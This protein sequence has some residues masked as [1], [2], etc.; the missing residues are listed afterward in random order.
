MSRAVAGT[1]GSDHY[2]RMV[3]EHRYQRL[4]MFKKL[5]YPLAYLTLIGAVGKLAWHGYAFSTGIR[6]PTFFYT[7]AL[8]AVGAMVSWLLGKLG[9]GRESLFYV[10]AYMISV[11]L[12]AATQITTMYAYHTMWPAEAKLPHQLAQH[13]SRTLG[14]E[15]E[16]TR[17]TLRSVEM[18]VD[19]T[20]S[21][22]SGIAT[23][24]VY[25]YVSD[26]IQGKREDNERK[27]R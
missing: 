10:K 20:L 17:S 21:F 15:Y 5:S 2:Y 12:M 13:I 6:L 8:C 1:D 11:G 14:Y 4:S 25:Q 9:T 19:G 3:V 7:I 23:F 18:C 16:S 26:K 22:I 27:A 24:F